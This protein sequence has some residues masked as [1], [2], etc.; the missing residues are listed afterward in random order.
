M[1]MVMVGRKKR[2]RQ[3]E[4]LGQFGD[5]SS[6]DEN[7][8]EGSENFL[9]RIRTFGEKLTAKIVNFNPERLSEK[10]GKSISTLQRIAIS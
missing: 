3:F 5:N 8:V 1:N 6:N 7:E 4:Q 2:R 10:P 9:D